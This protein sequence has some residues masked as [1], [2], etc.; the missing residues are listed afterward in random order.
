MSPWMPQSLHVQLMSVAPGNKLNICVV[1]QK[2]ARKE[3]HQQG[4]LKELAIDQGGK[5]PLTQI[6]IPVVWKAAYYPLH[7]CFKSFRGVHVT[8]H[9]LLDVVV[10]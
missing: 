4:T 8:E 3:N 1:Q 10:V 5:R 6:D 7:E 9:R 2:G